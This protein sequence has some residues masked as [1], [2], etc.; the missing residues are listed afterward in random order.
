M[1]INTIPI[2]DIFKNDIYFIF[3]CFKSIVLNTQSFGV[4]IEFD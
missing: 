3:K 1:K 4:I 2:F